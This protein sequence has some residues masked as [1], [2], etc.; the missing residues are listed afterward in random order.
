[1]KLYIDTNL[2]KERKKNKLLNLKKTL[3]EPY[4]GVTQGIIILEING[5]EFEFK[6][7]NVPQYLNVL[8]TGL[9]HG[10]AAGQLKKFNSKPFGEKELR[11]I[12]IR[13]K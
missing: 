11:D 13:V 9:I 6:S 5:E 7:K 1:M 4:A 2:E 3:I 8:L 10:T 12:R